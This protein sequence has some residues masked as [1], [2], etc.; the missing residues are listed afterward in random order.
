MLVQPTSR[1]VVGVEAD[2]PLA[3]G[4]LLRAPMSEHVSQTFASSCSFCASATT[5]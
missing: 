2:V 3:F 5:F 1:R 4:P